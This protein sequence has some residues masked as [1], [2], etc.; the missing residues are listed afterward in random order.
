MSIRVVST[1][2]SEARVRS[3]VFRILE[4]NV[5]C[6][7][8]TVTAATRAHINTAYFCYSDDLELYFLITDGCL[9]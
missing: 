2:Y 5:L 4:E 8:A 7:I 1:G 6:S 3:S 9:F